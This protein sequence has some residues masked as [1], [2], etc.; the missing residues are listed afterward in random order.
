MSQLIIDV[1]F[2][3]VFLLL[4]IMMAKIRVNAFEHNKDSYRY[5]FF[6]IS[7]LGVVSL[8]Q[9]ASHQNLFDS[10][11]FLSESVYRE[12]TLGIGVVSG[13]TLMIAGASIWL[14]GKNKKTKETTNPGNSSRTLDIEKAI[15]YS[16]NLQTA[17]ERIPRMI[18]RDF[19]FM[20]YAVFTRQNRLKKYVCTAYE[21]LE[22]NEVQQF[23]NFNFSTIG[24]RKQTAE[25][26]SKIPHDYCFPVTV[27][28]RAQVILLFR[29]NRGET[30][31]EV[32]KKS[33]E[34]IARVLSYRINNEYINKKEQ[35]YSNCWQ[36]SGHI[37]NILAVK[38][39]ISSNLPIL[40]RL[41]NQAVGAEYFSLV[42]LG[43][44][45]TN[46]KVYTAGINGNI[47]LDG[48]NSSIMKNAHF[49]KILAEKK[50]VL[51]ENINEVGS[52]A[53]DSMFVGC[54]QCSLMSQPI[55]VNNQVVAILTLG[56]SAAAHFSRKDQLLT[57]AMAY[58]MT[59]AIESELNQQSLFERDRCLAAINGFESAV[60]K[61]TDIDSLLKAAVDLLINNLSTTMVRITVLDDFRTRLKIAAVKTIRPMADINTNDSVLSAELT[62]WHQIVAEE[63]RL[64]LINQNDAESRM[65][66][67]EIESLVF[68]GVKSALI[69]PIVV[70]GRTYGIITLGE[71]RAWERTSYNST[72]I[73]FCK[74][75]AAKIA[76]TVK[77]LQLSRMMITTKD[78]TD[79]YKNGTSDKS[80]LNRLKVPVTNL[81]GSL[82]IL[83]IKGSQMDS[84][85][86]RILSRMEES[87]N[88]I[89]NLLNDY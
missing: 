7:V 35:F 10:V 82:E 16:Q 30:V 80:L 31:T 56:H 84:D 22:K 8:L 87:S 25:I 77:L 74:T 12:L 68:P 38:N 65:G 26:I 13:V 49:R 54:G 86:N 53:A 73:S 19:N 32:E 21:G 36:F 17:L 14:P 69:V 2:T 47:L 71:M 5:T 24:A 48:G 83:K 89:V 59:S 33:L 79:R 4:L 18:S 57:E 75:I 46:P 52:Q 42:T 88:D 20:T 50:P 41:F 39:S 61:A 70:S 64:L 76:D 66:K 78:T 3:T 11:P 67:S 43:K 62:H 72:A 55:I 1:F 51:I 45:Q 29:K 34:G 44:R 58:A 28:D 40:H 15:F 60:R 37:K 23:K 27:N 85:A 63:G 6:G 81:Q 9:M